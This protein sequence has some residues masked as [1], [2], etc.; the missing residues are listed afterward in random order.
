MDRSRTLAQIYIDNVTKNSDVWNRDICAS[1]DD[2]VRRISQQSETTEE[3][4]KQQAYVENLP[5]KEL[6]QLKEKLSTAANIAIIVNA[7]IY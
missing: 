5:F 4:V 3:L 2:I 7:F 6:M 1:F